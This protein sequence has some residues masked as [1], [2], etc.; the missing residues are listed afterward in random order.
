MLFKAYFP[1]PYPEIRYVLLLPHQRSPLAAVVERDGKIYFRL[2]DV[3]AVL[4]RSQVYE[5]AKHFENLALQSK[6]V[7]PFKKDYPVITKKSK[8][9]PLDMVFNMLKVETQTSLVTSFSTAF[10]TGYCMCTKLK[11]YVCGELQNLSHL[12]DLKIV[13]DQWNLI[14]EMDPRLL[15]K[16]KNCA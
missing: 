12:G 3:G 16:Y 5:F 13:H 2:V 7:L 6:D 8:F 14:E 4:G 1:K 11:Q 10:N 15:T 9:I